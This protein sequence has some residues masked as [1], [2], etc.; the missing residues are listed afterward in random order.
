MKRVLQIVLGIVAV[1]SGVVLYNLLRDA[2]WAH[3]WLKS[4][5]VF[6]PE[7]GT[8]IAVFELHHSAK[9]NELRHERNKLAKDNNELQGAQNKLV[10]DNN[11]LAGENNRLAKQNNDLQRELQ[12]E[13]NEHLAEIARQ[14][15]R[16]QTEAEVNAGK[17]RQHLGSPVVALN[18]DNSR[19]GGGPLIAEV[20]GDNI[21]AFFTPAQQGSQSFVVYADCKDLEVIEIPIGACPLQ[22]KVNKRYGDFVQLG[23]IK[24]WEDRKTPSAMPTFERGGAAYNAQFRKPRSPETRTLSIY[25]SKDGGNSFLLETSTGEHFVGNNK[26]VSIRFLSQQVEYLSDGFQRSSAGTGESHYPLFV[27]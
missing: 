18:G 14:M 20:T 24:R 1:V 9:A 23:E 21:V 12:S 15:Q 2:Q 6:L 5:L 13:R 16:P 7:L 19:W 25:T 11:T 27:C 17:L 4:T 8:V 3:S 22:V 26:A 10:E